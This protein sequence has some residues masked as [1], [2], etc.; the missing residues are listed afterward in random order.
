MATDHAQSLRLGQR[1]V[2]PTPGVQ[3]VAVASLPSVAYRGQLVYALDIDEFRVFDGDA[4]QI[5]TAAT[6]GGLQMFVQ[7]TAPVADNVGDLWLKDTTYQIYVWDGTTWQEVQDPTADAAAAAAAA[8]QVDATSALGLATNAQATADGKITAFY[9]SLEPALPTE[10]PQEGDIWYR[11][12]DNRAF[13]YHSGAFVEIQDA[14]IV[15][16]LT[17]AGTAQATADQKISSYF[18][19]GPPWA[20]GSAGHGNDIGDLWY[21]TDDNN[22]PYRWDGNWTPVQDGTIAIAQTAANTAQAAADAAQATADSALT[23]ATTDGNPPSSS[24]TPET[25]SGIGLFITKWAPITN[26]DPVTYEIHVSAVSGFTA[27][28]STLVGQT[29]ASQFVVKAL[30]GS[31]PAPGD[32]D[33]RVLDYDTTYYVRIIAKDADGAAAQSAQTS[34]MVFRVTGVDLQADSVTAA[35]IVSGTIT[36]DLLDANMIVAG[37]IQTAETGQRVALGNTG[38]QGYKPDNSLMINLPTDGSEGLIDLEVVARGLTAQDGASLYGDSEL[39]A[40]STI[41]LQAGITS[42]SSTPQVGVTYDA[43]QISTAAVAMVDKTGD[44]GTFDLVPSEVYAI[45]WKD[46]ATDYWVLHQIRSNGTRSWFFKVSDGTPTDAVTG[47]YFTDTTDWAFYSVWQITGVGSTAGV[48]R[49]ARWI[50]DGAANTYYMHSPAGLN[51]YSR[52]NGVASPTIG[53]DGTNIFTAEIISGNLRIRYWIPDGSGNNLASPIDTYESGTAAAYTNSDS[54][55]TILVG[56]FDV[57]AGRYAV[58]QRGVSY[59]ARLL[60]AVAGSP[61][62]LYPAGS[63]NNWAS[64][65]KEAFSWESPTT[66]RRGM[67]W[68]SANGVFWT[69]GSDGFMY[70]HTGEQWDPAV[71]SSTFWAKQTFYDSVGTTHET[72]PQ[73]PNKS[74]AGKRRAKNFYTVPTIPSGGVDDPNQVRLYMARGATAPANTSYHLQYT[75]STNTTWTTMATATANPPTTNNFPGATPGKISTADGTS[76]VISGDG[77]IKLGGT[78][79][80][81]GYPTRFVLTSGTSWSKPAGLKAAYFEAVGAGGAG[82]GAAS[83]S[84]GNHSCGA[85]GG[86]GGTAK[87]LVLAANIPSTVTYAIGAAGTGVS[88]AAGNNGGNTTITLTSTTLT[89]NGG[90]GGQSTILAASGFGPAPGAGGTATGGDANFT[91][92]GGGAGWGNA[93]F[94]IG[95]AGGSSVYGAGAGGRGTATTA[96]FGG[97][98]GGNYGGGGGGAI[99]CNGTGAQV[100]GNGGPGVV[101]ITCYF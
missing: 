79:V 62:G 29:T 65:N 27:N 91:G 60:N 22:K 3:L 21:D 92:G 96:A 93:G 47:R 75:G 12:S 82:G 35:N 84:A 63:S 32:P 70:K 48:Y 34:A 61:G 76:L 45:E 98:A 30:P 86:A 67:A 2:A 6:T 11:T 50:P 25:L 58:A 94:A 46:A 74:Y 55:C 59:N 64:A 90:G 99:C 13:I 28:S 68:D 43:I 83:A 18:Q 16:A 44:L 41:V 33:P 100:G 69:F 95:G 42:P 80:S 23:A 77:T 7:A 56:N 24:P 81:V 89:G 97:L 31:P 14:A 5:P 10:D 8:A 57:G 1:G 53:S 78:D 85:G 88:A 72:Q 38:L 73:S 71:S 37:Q 66:N 19:T 4:W 20:N 101:F 17:Q 52:Q 40:D 39:N 26:A 36:G 87:A 51:R 49:M 15:D 54:M 9:Q